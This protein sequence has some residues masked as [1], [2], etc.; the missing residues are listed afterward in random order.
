[1]KRVGR[2]HERHLNPFR[3]KRPHH[4]DLHRGGA[5]HPVPLHPEA[6][7][8]YEVKHGVTRTVVLTKRYAI[9]LPW[10]QGHSVLRGWLANRSEWK[11]RRRPDVLRPVLTLGHFVVVFPRVSTYVEW[12][13][14]F[15]WNFTKFVLPD[16]P[17]GDEAKESSWGLHDM[18]FV[19]IDFDRAW[20]SPG[21]GIVGG[22]YYGNQERLAR[23]WMKLPY[24]PELT[25][26]P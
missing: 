1:M 7:G 11:Q 22:L 23:K 13:A 8:R 15:V 18:K 16:Y 17:D 25:S 12:G 5:D 6:V 19:L 21:R 10:G 3:L 9:K 2:G 26:N 24:N 4:R 20:E 14:S